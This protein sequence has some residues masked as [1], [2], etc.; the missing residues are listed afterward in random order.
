MQRTEVI[1]RIERAIA[2][3]GAKRAWLDAQTRH[4]GSDARPAASSG[5]GGVA[6]AD[7]EHTR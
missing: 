3:R 1:A 6:D 4:G 5:A 7:G 2:G